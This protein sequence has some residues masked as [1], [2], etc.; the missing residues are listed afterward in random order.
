MRKAVRFL[1]K[2]VFFFC[3]VKAKLQQ[4]HPN[5]PEQIINLALDSVHYDSDRANQI[6][7]IMEQEDSKSEQKSDVIDTV[8]EIVTVEVKDNQ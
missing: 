7:Q 1:A 2:M 8:E 6:L 4:D 5:I 3:L